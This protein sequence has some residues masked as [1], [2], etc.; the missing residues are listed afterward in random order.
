MPNAMPVRFGVAGITAAFVMLSG[1]VCT[2]SFTLEEYR[3][4][5]WDR[6]NERQRVYEQRL[7]HMAETW[8][9]GEPVCVEVMWPRRVQDRTHWRRMIVTPQFDDAS[10]ARLT[11]HPRNVAVSRGYVDPCQIVGVPPSSADKIV[12]DVVVQEQRSD[13][14]IELDRVTIERPIQIIPTAQESST[15]DQGDH[16]TD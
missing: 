12:F 1:C 3:R 5:S 16:A 7:I 10:S 8:S 9:E 13:D 4:E 6:H 15:A 14:W 11:I 2:G